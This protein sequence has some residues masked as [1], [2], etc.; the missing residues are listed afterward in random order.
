[1][2]AF[3]NLPPCQQLDRNKAQCMFAQNY[4]VKE[5][6]VSLLKPDLRVVPSVSSTLAVFLNEVGTEGGPLL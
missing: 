4:V 3:I 6:V 1:M 5:T 2:G